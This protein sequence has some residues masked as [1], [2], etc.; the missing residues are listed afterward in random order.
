MNGIIFFF[1]YHRGNT[2]KIAEAMA[3]RLG[4]TAVDIAARFGATAADIA[5]LGAATVDIAQ[6]KTA[7]G[8]LSGAELVGFG[9]GIDGGSHYPRLLKFAADLPPADGKKAFI[10]STAAI[11]NQKKMTKNHTALR[12]LLVAKGFEVVGEFA[13]AGYTVRSIFTLVGGANKGKP[14][15]EDLSRA[16]AFAESLLN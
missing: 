8:A 10:F 2:K 4:A 13:C 3:A 1:S 6:N 7:E 11:Y 9:A 5:P 14:N 12:N 15:A 16:E